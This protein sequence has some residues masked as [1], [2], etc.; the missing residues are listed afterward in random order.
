MRIEKIIEDKKNKQKTTSVI[1]R[2]KE[3]TLKDL[4]KELK[5]LKINRSAFLI[6]MIEAFLNEQSKT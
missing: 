3:S 5:K 1:F 4:D 2:I 6:T